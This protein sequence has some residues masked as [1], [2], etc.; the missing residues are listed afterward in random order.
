LRVPSSRSATAS[1]SRGRTTHCHVATRPTSIR[2]HR[3]TARP[4]ST[5]TLSTRAP[6]RQGLLLHRG[7]DREPADPGR[8][9]PG[10]VRGRAEG[11]RTEASAAR[12]T[13]DP[14]GTGI[15]RRQ[16]DR[17]LW[18]AGRR[19]PRVP[20]RNPA[21]RGRARRLRRVG[22]VALLRGSRPRMAQTRS[23]TMRGLGCPFCTHKR[24]ARSEALS[25]TRPDIAAHDTGPGTAR[26]CPTTSPSD[27]ITRS[28][29]SAQPTRPTPGGRGSRA[30]RRC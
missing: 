24:V 10:R 2:T 22:L 23:R 13:A 28:G 26:S 14:P 5:S 19:V 21:A 17:R 20:Q 15:G 4:A 29:G 9:G 3:T 8:R 12:K 27:P 6:R 11:T 7:R 25:V 18:L 16:D 30:A 1:R